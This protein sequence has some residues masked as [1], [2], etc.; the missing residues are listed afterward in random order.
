MAPAMAHFPILHWL[1][2]LAV[3]LVL[4]ARLIGGPRT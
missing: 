1:I 3:T 4:G 2:L